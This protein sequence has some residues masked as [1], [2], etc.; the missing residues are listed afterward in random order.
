MRGD[1][2]WKKLRLLSKR[3]SF[4]N[5]DKKYKLYVCIPVRDRLIFTQKC[6]ESIYLNSSA[7]ESINIYIFDNYSELTDERILTFSR[8]LKEG[9]IKYYSYDTEESTTKCFAK[10]VIIKRWIEMMIEKD[11]VE[12]LVIDKDKYIKPVYMIS[13]NDMLYG[14]NWDTYFISALEAVKYVAP[15]TKFLVKSPGFEIE[16]DRSNEFS[17]IVN[18]YNGKKFLLGH[19]SNGGNGACW[20]MN[21]DM[22]KEIK[23]TNEEMALVYE[24]CKQSDS[25]TWEKLRHKYPE[26]NYLAAVIPP[27]NN[28]PLVEHFG[29]LLGSVCISVTNSIYDE[30]VKTEYAN[31]ELQYEN[32]SIQEIFNSNVKQGEW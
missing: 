26:M 9:K 12:K 20:V 32:M 1:M 18:I 19:A 11:D 23:W 15:Q 6:I 30:S 21:Y 13:D 25:L 27:D 29:G 7:F 28:E 4:L 2:S 3:K 24:K 16:L 22:L 8:L 14:P 31:N 10:S 17:K 5:K